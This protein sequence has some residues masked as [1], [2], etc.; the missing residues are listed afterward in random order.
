[1]AFRIPAPAR[2][3]RRL[4]NGEYELIAVSQV[5]VLLDLLTRTVKSVFSKWLGPINDAQ[6]H[7]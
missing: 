2:A 7:P 3:P 4:L 1:M 5:G 6:A